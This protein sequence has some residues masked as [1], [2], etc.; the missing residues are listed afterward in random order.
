V[1]WLLGEDPVDRRAKS[2]RR[3]VVLPPEGFLPLAGFCAFLGA[4]AALAAGAA[5]AGLRAATLFGVRDA[6]TGASCHGSSPSPPYSIYSSTLFLL[7]LL[8]F[9]TLSVTFSLSFLFSFFFLFNHPTFPT[10]PLLKN[11]SLVSCSRPL[12]QV[13]VS[14]GSGT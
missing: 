10:S 9:T 7:L 14:E 2:T 5:V 1:G 13:V 6:F 3:A 4:L 11:Y 12:T 8:P